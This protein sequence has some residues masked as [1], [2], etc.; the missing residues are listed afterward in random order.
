MYVHDHFIP[1]LCRLCLI[2]LC[3]NSI[4][5]RFFLFPFDLFLICL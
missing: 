1:N 5:L 2:G 4:N 3:E